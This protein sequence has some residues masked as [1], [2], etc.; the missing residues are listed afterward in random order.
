VV[1]TCRE[2]VEKDKVA[3][4]KHLATSNLPR[5]EL[6]DSPGNPA[7]LSRKGGM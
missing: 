6:L 4:S 5:K 1:N 2:I 7:T 3:P